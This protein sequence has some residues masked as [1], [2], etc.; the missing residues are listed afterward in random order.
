LPAEYDRHEGCRREATLQKPIAAAL[1]ADSVVISLPRAA[2]PIPVDEVAFAI[3]GIDSTELTEPSLQ[4]ALERVRDAASRREAG[5]SLWVAASLSGNPTQLRTFEDTPRSSGEVS[6]AAAMVG[7]H[8]DGELR[9]AAAA[10]PQDGHIVRLDGSLLQAVLG[11]WLLGVSTLDRW[12]GSAWDGSLILGNAA[13]PIPGLM[14]ER[15]TSPPF[16]PKALHWIGPWRVSVLLG[17]LEH[18]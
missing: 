8:W 2:W 11:K 10:S 16:S 13:R 17:Q 6:A 15:R 7:E 14:L 5:R 18:D 9:V 4:A 1:L 3:D 12:W